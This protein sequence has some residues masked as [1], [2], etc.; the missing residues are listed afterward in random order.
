MVQ[1]H[2]S[3]FCFNF[4]V[5]LS[6]ISSEAK[7]A[8]YSH[9]EFSKAASVNMGSWSTITSIRPGT[10]PPVFP[11]PFLLSLAQ[12]ALLMGVP[13]GSR[14]RR[15]VDSEAMVSGSPRVPTPLP[16]ASSG[17]TLPFPFPPLGFGIVRCNQFEVVRHWAAG[18]FSCKDNRTCI[19]PLIMLDISFTENRK[20][21]FHACSSSRYMYQMTC[22]TLQ[23]NEK[24]SKRNNLALSSRNDRSH[25]NLLKRK[26][27]WMFLRQNSGY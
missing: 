15:R 6:D 10:A 4:L 21:T 5:L 2:S 18:S 25:K 24:W 26:T 8:G 3:V 19:N 22:T 16:I 20:K 9:S 17:A 14:G 13:I 12:N 11:L 23:L 7:F 1:A 27:N